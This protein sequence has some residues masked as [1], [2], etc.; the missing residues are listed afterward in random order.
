MLFNCKLFN[1]HFVEVKVYGIK[2]EATTWVTSFLILLV[3]ISLVTSQ[4]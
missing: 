2:K 4:R 3:D 1:A